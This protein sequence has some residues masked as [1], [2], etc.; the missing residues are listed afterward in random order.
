[1]LVSMPLN[2]PLFVVNPAAGNGRAARAIERAAVGFPG[3]AEVVYTSGPGDAAELAFRGAVDGSSTVVAVGGDGTVQEVVS[4]LM[5]CPEPPPMGI[6]AAGS[7]NDL[8]RTLRLPSDPVAAARLAWSE[9]AGTVDVGACNDRYFLNVAGV[10]LDTKVALA[11]N[12]RSGRLSRGRLG[13]VLQA[14]AE[15]RTYENLE[16]TIRMDDRV[17][18]TRS[19]LMAVANG[20]YFAGGMMICPEANPAD[21]WLDVCIGG[22]LGHGET[23]VLI[24]AIFV[25]QHGRSRKVAF[26]RART[27]RIEGPEGLEVQLDGEILDR[28]PAEFRVLPGALRIAGWTPS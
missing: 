16:L 9:V 22:D 3:P 15:L 19:L 23:L 21:G 1:M 26:H 27:V 18:T 5:R 25:G 14:L 7:G 4:G 6:V 10:G 2:R 17:V 12:A 28:L 13:Y 20:R 24:P 8:V 11:V